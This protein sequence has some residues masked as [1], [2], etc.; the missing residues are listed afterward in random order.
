MSLSLVAKTFSRVNRAASSINPFALVRKQEMAE[1][2]VHI[3][4]LEESLSSHSVGHW[5]TAAEL[6]LS[7]DSRWKKIREQAMA[8]WA[9]DGV[10]KRI[11]D[12]YTEW[13]LAGGIRHSTN[14]S[15][16]WA[17]AT[18]K[19]LWPEGL[20]QFYTD[21]MFYFCIM[22]ELYFLPK[23]DGIR[24][25]I[26]YELISP[27]EVINVY[28]DAAS[29]KIFFDRQWQETNVSK[30]N[31]DGTLDVTLNNK[32]QAYS[33]DEVFIIKW[34]STANRGLPFVQ[35]IIHWTMIY[36]EWLKDRAITNRMRSFAFLKRTLKSHP[37]VAKLKA[38]SFS[39]QLMKS[40]S[41]VP[42]RNDQYGYGYKAEKM[43]TGGILTEDEGTEWDTITFPIQG[44][45]ASPDGHAFRQQVCALTGIPEALLFS[46]DK[47]KLDAADSRVE[48][49]VRKIEYYREMFTNH[50]NAI[51]HHCR[52]VE[53][54]RSKNIKV[55][56]AGRRVNT[57]VHLHFKP[58]A[59]GERRFVTED[60]NKAMIGGQISR[61]TAME[62]SPF[63]TDPDI[64]EER[65]KSEY[66]NEMNTEFLDRIGTA[67]SNRDDEDT[68][69]KK[70][71]KDEDAGT[72]T[73]KRV[74]KNKGG[75]EK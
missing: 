22:G 31:R 57:R 30:S 36:N 44:D 19:R 58:A 60:L 23:F 62:V 2:L 64:E 50:I 71:S 68:D 41:Y 53:L 51:L 63:V 3:E 11:C 38:D 59:V 54:V 37:G 74:N 8:G 29:G 5:V 21:Y 25:L 46:D 72:R 52:N 67:K 15:A 73:K 66:G 13:G 7:G 35:P 40:D 49:L 34:N 39:S 9:A 69:N 75:G 70:K 42:G 1:M 16:G 28:E 33:S 26:G 65:I 32:R 55:A 47:S 43:P 27:L 17:E 20:F 61:Q 6:N 56:L 14:S 12:H 18:I 10:V 24:Q 48:S 4:Q 45:D